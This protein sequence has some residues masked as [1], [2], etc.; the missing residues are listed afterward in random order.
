MLVVLVLVRDAGSTLFGNY[1]AEVT[2]RVEP[3]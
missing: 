1:K 3:D 2:G